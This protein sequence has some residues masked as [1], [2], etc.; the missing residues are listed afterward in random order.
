MSI[1]IRTGRSPS[2]EVDPR[3]QMLFLVEVAKQ[4]HVQS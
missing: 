2:T 3:L 4:Q 1:A